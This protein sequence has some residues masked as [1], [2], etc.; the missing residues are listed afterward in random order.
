MILNL[1]LLPR[2]KNPF[3]F[4][5]HEIHRIPC[6]VGVWAD[7]GI[8]CGQR[9]GAEPGGGEGVVD[10]RAEVVQT[11]GRVP[12]LAAESVAGGGITPVC[13]SSGLDV[14]PVRVIMVHSEG[15]PGRICHHA[16]APQMVSHE[17]AVL[18]SCPSE[19]DVSSVEQH[20]LGHAVAVY[21]VA[22]IG[23]SE[24]SAVPY[25]RG[26]LHI[27]GKLTPVGGV[28]ERSRALRCHNLLRQAGGVVCE[29]GT[30]KGGE[31]AVGIVTAACYSVAVIDKPG[32]SN[33]A[34]QVIAV[35]SAQAVGKAGP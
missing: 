8:V 6:A 9:V 4:R 23:E 26:V 33:I 11:G 10:A 16:H 27:A 35:A 19:V 1:P 34:V 25:G 31:V 30:A 5:I 20:A 17:E 3:S 12:L 22:R 13:A 2:N 21:H 32:G 28:P 24:R 15:R 18:R 29:G 14:V 7:A